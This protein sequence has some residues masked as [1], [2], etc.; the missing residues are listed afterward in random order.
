M[1][2]NRH[3]GDHVNSKKFPRNLGYFFS[4][5]FMFVPLICKSI[6]FFLWIQM[7]LKCS[8]IKYEVLMTISSHLD[9]LFWPTPKNLQKNKKIITNTFVAQQFFN[10]IVA[11]FFCRFFINISTSK[12]FFIFVVPSQK[13]TQKLKALA[14]IMRWYDGDL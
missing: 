7:M 9:L 13:S 3:I 11:K 10:K 2:F 14:K 8:E 1:K 12:I 6:S 4:G 5:G